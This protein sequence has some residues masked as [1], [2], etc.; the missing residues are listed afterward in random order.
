LIVLRPC[1]RQDPAN[2][3]ERFEVLAYAVTTAAVL[4]REVKPYSTDPDNGDDPY[5]TTFSLTTFKLGVTVAPSYWSQLEG[6]FS[7][8]G[9]RVNDWTLPLPPELISV[10]RERLSRKEAPPA[11]RRR[12]SAAP[13]GAPAG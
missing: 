10:V 6:R 4:V 1:V 2:K 5:S 8:L 13:D 9:G 7:V 3:G 11:E 12:P